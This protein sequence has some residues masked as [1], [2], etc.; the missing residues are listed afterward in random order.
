MRLAQ[1]IDELGGAPTRPEH[2]YLERLARN[3]TRTISAPRIV[4]KPAT[5]GACAV[6]RKRRR[7]LPPTM[8]W[9]AWVA[10]VLVFVFF[11]AF[12]SFRLGIEPA[13]MHD[14]YEYTYP[15]FSLAERGDF[16]SPLLGPGL[17]VEKRTYNL[18]VY[19]YASVH[20]VLIRIFGDGAESIPLANTFHFALLAG[21]GASFLIRREAFLGVFVFLLALVSDGRMVEAAR[22]GRPEMTA[23]CC[24]TLAILALWL[25]LGEGRRSPLVLL[26]T[27]AWLTAGVLSH[28]SVVFFALGLALVFA[29]PVVREAGPRQLA[30]ALVPGLAVAALYGYFLL[31][32]DVA[33]IRGQMAPSHGDVLVG[34][35]LLPLLDGDWAGFWALVVEFV[36]IHAGPPW[37]W[38]GFL[39]AVALPSLAP[40]P[41]ARAAR[42]LAVVYGV[43]FVV[44]LFCLKHF[45]LS[46]RVIYQATLYLALALLADRLLAEAGRWL[47]RPVWTRALRLAVIAALVVLAAQSMARFRDRLLGQLSPFG[48][49]Q[50]ALTFALLESGA[51]PGDRVF[52]PS[53]FG[54]HLR[55]KFDVVAYP[56]PK[57]YRGRWSPAFRDGVKKV[58]GAET[59]ARVR[60]AELCD[61]M[62]L[63]FVLPRFVIAWDAD[64]SIMWPFNQFLRRYPDVPGMEVARGR[65]ARL[66]APY[67]GTVRAYRLSFTD[68]ILALDRTLH[69]AQIGCP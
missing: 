32:D 13:L 23:G 39:A 12:Y 67:G 57:F 20:A 34:F 54:F 37:L 64:Y 19:Y 62:G 69:K 6:G 17:N 65:R 10:A 38:L 42:Y 30:A 29:P 18:I 53:P 4:T 50:G 47:G 68:E 28:T 44:H 27:T 26:A 9:F 52:V 33:N 63:A 59:V 31:T 35:R 66:P 3:H 16:G 36:K 22:H 43:S 51:R 21:A 25:W 61:A 14:D 56:A 58:W 60:R 15:S 46:Y 11:Y 55:K 48:Q 45:V 2:D 7:W 8:R 40:H 5:A 49:L 41:L 24:L 1:E